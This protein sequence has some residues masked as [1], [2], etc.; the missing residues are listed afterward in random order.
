MTASRDD[1]QPSHEEE[2]RRRRFFNV[3]ASVLVEGKW[4]GA[5]QLAQTRINNRSQFVAKWSHLET[6]RASLRRRDGGVFRAEAV[7]LKVSVPLLN[8]AAVLVPDCGRHYVKSL[9]L[10]DL[11]NGVYQLSAANGGHPFLALADEGGEF[12]FGFGWLSAVGEVKVQ[13]V[14]PRMSH[15]S[16]MLGGDDFLVIEF[17][18]SGPLEDITVLDV[19]AFSCRDSETWFHALRQYAQ[20]IQRQEDISYPSNPAAWLPTW[21]TWTA[22]CSRDLTQER[23]LANARVARELRIGTIVIDDGWFGPGLDDDGGVLNLGDYEPDPRRLPDFPDLVRRLHAMDLKVLLWHAPLCLARTS[24]SYA[25]LKRYAIHRD[26]EE[27]TS[28]N[29]LAMLCPACP[30]VRGYVADETERL[31]RSYGVDGLKVDLHNCLP[32]GPCDSGEHEHDCR[33]SLTALDRCMSAQWERAVATKRDVLVELKQDYGNAR[34][35]RHGTMVRAGD[36]AYD[37]DTNCRRCFYTQAFAPC[38]HSDYLVTSADTPPHSM[39]LLMIRAMTAGVPT[40]S[41]DL[42]RIGKPLQGVIKRWLEFYEAHVTMFQTPREP[43][44]NDMSVW[45]GGTPE[46]AWVSALRNAREVFLPEAARLFLMNGTSR[47]ELY[48]RVNRSQ[49]V[50][51]LRCDGLNGAAP[52]RHEQLQDGGRLAIPSG[53][54]LEILS[55]SAQSAVGLSRFRVPQSRGT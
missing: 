21:C 44:T 40:L 11:R 35:A 53:S 24:R 27:F 3:A 47:D 14:M 5:G 22:F 36:T 6:I 48:I 54:M 7:S 31:L 17:V 33:D 26:G 18:S 39:D 38:V 4:H 41:L 50:R 37:M 34:L 45:Q 12:C 20:L 52:S 8:Y 19:E 9:R 1:S 2:G 46:C 30:D 29:G 16:A 25:R 13:T 28:V 55:S 23:V 32:S 43:Q 49:T 15:R 10:L 51:L 42:L